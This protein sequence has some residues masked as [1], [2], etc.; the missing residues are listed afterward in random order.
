MLAMFQKSNV[1]Q[2][3]AYLTW[4]KAPAE[5]SDQ[6]EPQV[7]RGKKTKKP[8]KVIKV[9][10]WTIAN[11]QKC[12]SQ[13]GDHVLP[14]ATCNFPQKIN[15]HFWNISNMAFKFIKDKTCCSWS[16]KN[17]PQKNHEAIWDLQLFLREVQIF[18]G[19]CSVLEYVCCCTLC[20]K[21][22]KHTF[23]S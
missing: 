8:T 22:G 20:N 21:E 3:F 15:I 19:D 17:P 23:S 14:S 4:W 5:I 18:W 6:T 2:N 7:C 9:H 11:I 16:K 13:P 12:L 1:H 10:F